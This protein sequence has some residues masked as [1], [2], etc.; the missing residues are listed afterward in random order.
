M[1]EVEVRVVVL[2]EDWASARRGKRRREVSVGRYMVSCI[3]S[4]V[5]FEIWWCW[6]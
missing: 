6:R 5:D 1:V 3:R 2:P 4:F